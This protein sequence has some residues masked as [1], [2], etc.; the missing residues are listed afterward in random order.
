MAVGKHSQTK[1]IEDMIC[2]LVRCGAVVIEAR[3]A[4]LLA[5]IDGLIVVSLIVAGIT[6]AELARQD[7]CATPIGFFGCNW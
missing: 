2:S 3:N 5:F 1:E 6:I 7:D 4:L